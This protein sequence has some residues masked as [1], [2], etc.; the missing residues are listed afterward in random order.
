MHHLEKTGG[1]TVEKSIQNYLKNYDLY[2]RDWQAFFFEPGKALMEHSGA[3]AS[4][5][6]L[7]NEWYNFNKFS[8]VRNPTD[9]MKSMYVFGKYIFDNT[10]EN[11]ILPE[12]VALA[13][14]NSQI[15]NSGP[16]GF[17]RYMFYKD[18]YMV[19]PQSL[20]LKPMLQDGMIVDL[21]DLDERWKD[22]IKYLGFDNDIP[23]VKHRVL[24]SSSVS[25][26]SEIEKRIKKRFESDYDILPPLTGKDWK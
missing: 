5:D 21:L 10:P 13:Y 14:K 22:I 11:E 23:M 16:D 19:Q 9:I 15:Y 17:V 2:V 7:G 18:F 3:Q 20:R 1:T 8:T 6:F 26:S 4:L 25:F 12:G 24:G